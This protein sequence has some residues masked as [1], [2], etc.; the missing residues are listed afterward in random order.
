MGRGK[1]VSGRIG[2]PSSAYV[3]HRPK[4]LG[5]LSGANLA[6]HVDLEIEWAEDELDD[7]YRC[8]KDV[9][10][11]TPVSA[12]RLFDH[13]YASASH[14]DPIEALD[15]YAITRIIARTPLRSSDFDV[16]TTGSY[17]EDEVDSVKLRDARAQ[18]IDQA[19]NEFLALPAD[20]TTRM[21]WLLRREYG[22][23][24]PIVADCDYAIET[25]AAKDIILGA[26]EH[27][28]SLDRLAIVHYQRDVKIDWDQKLSPTDHVPVCVCRRMEDGSLRLVDGYHRLSAQIETPHSH[29]EI[30]VI[31]ATAKEKP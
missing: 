26:T 5:E 29:K 28:S 12:R 4:V 13:L 23:I 27:R 20:T 2:V 31:V 24:A 3:G 11:R 10:V 16:L 18:E 19:V 30:R 15:S 6:F 8:I 17:Y 14:G 9:E 7:D 22:D 1:R 25:V 21:E